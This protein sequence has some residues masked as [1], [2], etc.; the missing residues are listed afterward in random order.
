MNYG[1]YLSATGVQAS[2][3]R[4]DVIANNIANAETVGF[5]KDLA[6]FQQR[7]TEAQSR[8][9]LDST[10]PLLEGIGGGLF[11]APTQ[12]D[13]GQGDLESTGNVLDLGIQGSGFFKVNDSGKSRLTRDGRFMIDR[14][15]QLV[16]ANSKGQPVLDVD[17][18]PIQLDPNRPAA[19][20]TIDTLGQ[21]KQG[22]R[23]AAR[24]G[25]FEPA[26]RT[27]LHK[28]GGNLISY[29]DST[30]LLPAHAEIRSGFTERSNVEPA[31]ELTQLMDAQRQLEANA[32]MI[33][34][35]DQMLSRLVNDVGK[36]T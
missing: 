11:I 31:T 26:D 35:Q 36:I 33:R 17:G 28:V 16:M 1:L 5:K 34:F 29:P 25:V 9:S 30:Q 8:G 6:L 19:E 20:T 3:Y 21:I 7:P 2:S 4:Q 12:I 22:G 13:T 10:N 18:R 32:S 27:Q 24:V 14:N 15:G 23:I